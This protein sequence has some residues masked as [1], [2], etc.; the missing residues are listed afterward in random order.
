[1]DIQNINRGVPEERNHAPKP[2]RRLFRDYQQ[3]KRERKTAAAATATAIIII[4]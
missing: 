3:H 1:M 2:V 4:P